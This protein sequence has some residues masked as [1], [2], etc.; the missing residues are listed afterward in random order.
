MYSTINAPDATILE[1]AVFLGERPGDLRVLEYIEGVFDSSTSWDVR[2]GVHPVLTGYASTVQRPISFTDLADYRELR[3]RLASSDVLLVYA[4]MLANSIQLRNIAYT[5][6]PIINSFLDDGGVVVVLDDG[7]TDQIAA[8]PGAFDIPV[9][10]VTVSDTLTVSAPGSRR[11]QGIGPT[12]P[13][14]TEPP[15]SGRPP[16]TRP[17]SCTSSAKCSPIHDELQL[18]GPGPNHQRRVSQFELL[19]GFR[20]LERNEPACSFAVRESQ[21]R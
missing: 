8:G 19:R 1:N 3:N 20:D 14:R 5:W 11:R 21:R 17:P 15:S 2:P 13:R 6:N 12:L 4:Q 16:P 7:K 18:F 9:N 10:P